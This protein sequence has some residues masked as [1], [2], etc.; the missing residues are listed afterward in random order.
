[1]SNDADLISVEV[2]AAMWDRFFTVSPLVLVGTTEKGGE[3]NLAPKH[4]A[5]PL[6]WEG[7]FGFVCT[8]DHATYW[9][10][11]RTGVFTVSYPR[12]TQIVLASLAASPRDATTD[13]KPSLEAIDTIP[14]KVVDGVLLADGYLFFECEL[15]RV[16]D[17][18]GA[19][20]LM[21]GRIVAAHVRPDALRH[22]D[23][24]DQDLIFHRPLLTYLHPGRFSRIRRSL[25][26]P[27]YE[28]T[29]E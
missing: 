3:H 13:C 14:A 19:N 17:G 9:N 1:M 15:V 10:A 29:D 24:D 26:F 16:I 7:Y 21:V 20:S 22:F 28:A 6:G 23:V 27:F 2:G 18:F 4:M 25:S 11:K 5:V 12:P 8:P